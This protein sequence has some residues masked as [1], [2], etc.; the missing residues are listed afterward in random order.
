M[1]FLCVVIRQTG[2]RTINMKKGFTLIELLLV[3]AI[4]GI[5]IVL[6]LASFTTSLQKGRDSKRKNDLRQVGI[7][8]EAY[9]ADKGRYPIG[10][11]GS[12]TGASW[13]GAFTDGVTMYMTQ[14]P[15]DA[16]GSQQYYYVSD[17]TYFQIYA[18]LENTK[19]NDI[20]HNV[21]GQQR[22][23]TNTN[24]G[25]ATTTVSCNY[26]VSSTNKSTLDGQGTNYE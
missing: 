2:A 15:Q 11:A 24:C 1:E 18:R 6:G 14:L 5:L 10:N 21:S 3:I 16:V 4:L 22:V 17:G 13:G 8:L 7:A 25:N 19:D 12:I 9:F 26:G 20:V 23:F